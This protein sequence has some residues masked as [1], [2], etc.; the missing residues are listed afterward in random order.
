MSK[1]KLTY[2][3]NSEVTG[4]T[5]NGIVEVFVTENRTFI[6]KDEQGELFKKENP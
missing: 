1:L 5:D 2:E 6:V 3:P 4:T